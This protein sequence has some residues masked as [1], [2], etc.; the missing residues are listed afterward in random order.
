MDVG[1]IDGDKKP[2][3]I[4]GNMAAPIRGEENNN[5]WAQAAPLLILKNIMK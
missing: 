5:R 4:L 1:D 2:D 3:I